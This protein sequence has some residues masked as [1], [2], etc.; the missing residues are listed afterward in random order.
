VVNIVNDTTP[1]WQHARLFLTG[2]G[3]TEFLPNPRLDRWLRDLDLRTQAL[4]RHRAARQAEQRDHVLP[5]ARGLDTAAVDDL[6][7]FTGRQQALRDACGWL[8]HR[9]GPAAMVVTGDPGSG[10]S[11]LLSRLFVLADPKLRNRVPS[12]HTV[13][14]DTLPPIGSITRF[15][16]ARGQPPGDLLAALGEACDVE[17]ADPVSAENSVRPGHGIARCRVAGWSVV[18]QDSPG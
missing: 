10:K 5:R 14:A 2:D 18:G 16:H 13:P 8:R 3:I 11:A 1:G 7:L 6:W 17:D 9:G 4:R 12:L 15:I